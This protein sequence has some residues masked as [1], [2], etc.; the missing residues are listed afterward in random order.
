MK[1]INTRGDIYEYHST[2]DNIGA[3]N[4]TKNKIQSSGF[5]ILLRKQGSLILIYKGPKRKVA[6]PS[7]LVRSKG[8]VVSENGSRRK[9]V[10]YS[11]TRTGKRFVYT[12]KNGK[13]IKQYLKDTGSY[14]RT[15]VYR[16]A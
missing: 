7:R 16:K 1:S 11:E 2:V 12:Y 15:P 4:I 6:K 8:I 5:K 10:I 14:G 9:R 3:A 13:K